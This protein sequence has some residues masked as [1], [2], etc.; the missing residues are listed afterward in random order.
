MNARDYQIKI[1]TNIYR[2]QQAREEDDE[3]NFCV[4]TPFKRGSGSRAS[5]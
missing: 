1:D 5:M 2:T 4:E 3:S